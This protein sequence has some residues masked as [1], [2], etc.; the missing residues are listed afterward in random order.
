MTCPNE[1]SGCIY[2]RDMSPPVD[3]SVL[4]IEKLTGEFFERDV[5]TFFIKNPTSSDYNDMTYLQIEYQLNC[6]PVLIRA[7][8]LTDTTDLIMYYPKVGQT[9]SAPRG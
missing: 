6:F 8:S 3:G 1:D 2:D 7:N 4:K 9:F 5:C